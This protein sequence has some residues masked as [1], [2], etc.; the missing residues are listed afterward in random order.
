MLFRCCVLA[1]S[2]AAVPTMAADRRSPL[3]P[4]ETF[5]SD[6]VGHH[7]G[8]QSYGKEPVSM[9]L[10][11]YGGDSVSGM[12]CVDQGWVLGR[13]TLMM[14][15][16]W[17][18]PV[19]KVWVDYPMSLPPA[20]PIRLSF[21][22]AMK[23]ENVGRS[24]GVTFSCSLIV[25]GRQQEL[26]RQHHAGA[27]WK[28]FEFD[29]SAYAGKDV[30][31]RLQVEPG[32]KNDIN[33]DSASFGDAKIVIGAGPE[34]NLADRVRRLTN[35][36][37][38][39]ATENVSLLK[40]SNHRENGV[41]PSNLLPCSTTVE[42]SG[43]RFHFTYRG[44]DCRIVYAYQP[45]SGTLDDFTVQIDDGRVFQPALGGGAMASIKRQDGTQEMPLR[46]GRLLKTALEKDTL[47]VLWEYRV[48]DRPLQIDWQF[49]LANKALVVS[50][51]CTEPALSHFSLGDV[52][53]VSLRRQIAVPYLLGNVIYLPVENVFACRYLDWNQSH[54]S[55]CPQGEATY[56]AKTDGHRNPMFEVGY[57]AVS[58][59]LDEVLPNIPLPPSPYLAALGGRI[60]LDIWRHNKG[61]YQGDA[62]NLMALKDH[63]VDHLAIIQHD[64]Q[65]YGYDAKLP[66]HMPANTLYGGDP[67]LIAFGKT[68]NGYGVPWALHENYIDMYPD[69]PSYIP[70]ARI[71]QSDGT[72]SKGWYNCV[73]K[74]RSDWM[75]PGQGFAFAQKIAPAVHSRY[76][77]TAAYLD[78]STGVPPWAMLDYEAGQPMAAMAM[79]TVKHHATLFQ[80]LRDAHAGPLFGEGLYP[81]FWAGSCDATEAQ[82]EGREDHAPL[83]NFEL[84]KVHPQMVNH[85]IGYY[86][87]WLRYGW[88]HWGVN[89]GTM[90][91][92]DKYRAQE[93]AY[94]HA[95][96]I[97]GDQVNNIP[98]VVR[99]HHL[100]YPVQ[101]LYG[102]TKATE[103]R[104]EVG[105]QL[106]DAGVAM[107][108]GE[109]TRQRI[110]YEN[111]LTLW[112]NWQTEPWKIEGRTLPQWGFLAIGPNTEVWTALRDGRWADYAE[113]PEYVFADARTS[114]PMPYLSPEAEQRLRSLK[115]PG[116]S[117]S[118]G[119]TPDFT[120]RLNPPGTWIDF[121]R[122]ATDG[123]VKIQREP[124]RLVLFPYP[125]DKPFRVSIDVKGL[126]PTANV[127]AI[128]VRALAAGTQQDL[129]PVEFTL[130]DTKL[131]IVAGKTRVGRFVISW[132]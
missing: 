40:V 3:P 4:N 107:A 90:E 54:A 82:V 63:G 8:W 102:T 61:T 16:P 47:R 79:S 108:I 94:G 1:I 85:G 77:T 125:R 109:T 17:L 7:V 64:W 130:K 18:V 117:H 66:D 60:V 68:A 71:L 39:R 50:A 38:Y 128:K 92:I 80:F 110:L 21:G 42:R 57:I 19:G 20:G 45:V 106:V 100:V 41:N 9:P 67:G 113:C 81:F 2:F 32:P 6:I 43:D 126:A 22:I 112:V 83:L 11:W 37:A 116:K 70:N 73:T 97:G 65:H 132:K 13:R 111:G 114:F 48:D 10:D 24:D 69:S 75:K 91:Q 98:W 72:P 93:L 34:P 119:N 123:S 28:N 62:D 99:E 58:P 51:Q 49:K 26:M 46:D 76:G 31:L 89:A 131:E 52:G 53:S 105:G 56:S 121:G 59:R 25:D 124:D 12:F 88:P 115:Q 118:S 127:S 14:H 84:L 78:V 122:V 36:P 35:T 27:N 55:Q 15:P 120:V 29:L 86:E 87:R 129:G 5:L 30:V 103:I 33:N 23:P 74:M 101:N 104:Y 44:D 96:F 95:G